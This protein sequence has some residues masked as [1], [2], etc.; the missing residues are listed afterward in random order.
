MKQLARARKPQLIGFKRGAHRWGNL[1]SRAEMP[2]LAVPARGKAVK[3]TPRSGSDYPHHLD[4]VE[5][6]DEAYRWQVAI[7]EGGKPS[8]EMSVGGAFVNFP[9]RVTNMGSSEY[10]DVYLIPPS[11]SHL[12]SLNT[13]GESSQHTKYISWRRLERKGKSSSYWPVAFSSMCPKK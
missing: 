12:R 13:T 2:K 8:Y 1:P 3:H 11:P 10:M 9:L 7:I 5:Q 4:G 6:L